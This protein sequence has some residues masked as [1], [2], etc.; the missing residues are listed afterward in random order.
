M[1]SEDIICECKHSVE[2]HA[3]ESDFFKGGC[4]ACFSDYSII[5]PEK[6]SFGHLVVDKEKMCRVTNTTLFMN[7]INGLIE[8]STNE[9]QHMHDTRDRAIQY[10]QSL[11]TQIQEN[12]YRVRDVDIH[13]II[14]VL[15]DLK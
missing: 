4:Y 2:F 8:V 3:E 13:P 15:R 14:D 5:T 11:I 1:K 6:D 10:L 7:K 12:A 9:I